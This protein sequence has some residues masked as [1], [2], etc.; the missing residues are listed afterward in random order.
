[1]E[2]RGVRPDLL[3]V[4]SRGEGGLKRA[5]MGSTSS[6]IVQTVDVPTLVIRVPIFVNEAPP[7]RLP[8]TSGAELAAPLPRPDRRRQA[9]TSFLRKLCSLL[10]SNAARARRSRLRWTAAL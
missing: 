9:R 2:T 5:L 7:F 4:G 6:H 3:V 8:T 10:L 1:V